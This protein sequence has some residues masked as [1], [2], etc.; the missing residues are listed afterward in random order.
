MHHITDGSDSSFPVSS[1]TVSRRDARGGGCVAGDVS[2]CWSGSSSSKW[3][4]TSREDTI[5]DQFGYL[6]ITS[7]PVISEP[8]EKRYNK[9]Q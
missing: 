2:V 8:I 9:P 6:M 3:K 7:D 5:A 4:K 1:S